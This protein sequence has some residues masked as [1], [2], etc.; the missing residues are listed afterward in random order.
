MRLALLLLLVAAASPAAAAPEPRLADYVIGRFAL[1]ANDLPQ[2]ST[3]FGQALAGDPQ[4]AMLR[5]RAFEMALLAG[6]ERAAERLAVPLAR[7][8]PGNAQVALLQ[9]ARAMK[10]R[11]WDGADA[12]AGRLTGALATNTAPI[13]RA[14]ALQGGG[15]TEAALAL[16]KPQLTSEAVG[17]L[18]AEH[19]ARILHAAGRHAEA[20]EAITALPGARATD[21]VLVAA[22][23]LARAG[24]PADAEA[25][26]AGRPFD[27]ALD[28][29]R[30]RLAAN[31]PILPPASPREGAAALMSRVALELAG[32]GAGP[33]ALPYARLA[34]IAAPERA[35]SA[36]ILADL[37]GRAG[38]G[39]AALAALDPVAADPIWAGPVRATRASLLDDADREPDAR[40]LLERAAAQPNASVA[41]WVRLGDHHRSRERQADAARAYERAIAIAGTT[42]GP[43][44]WTLHFLRGGALEQAGDWPG[45]ETELRRALVLAPD[46]AIV[47]NY[48]GYSLLDRGLALPEAERLIRRAAELEPDNAAITDSLG[49]LY[50][51]TGRFPQAVAALERAVAGAPGDPTMNEHLGDAYWQVGRRIEARHRWRAALDGEPDAAQLARVRAKLDYGPGRAT[52]AAAPA[53]R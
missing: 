5:R 2:A 9:Y 12:A 34:V 1:E 16:L 37:L 19:R 17:N 52:L 49:W 22:D 41:D 51:R 21:L 25:L 30:A 8:E 11:D 18:R 28:A 4:S 29:A 36:L 24:R 53:A 13:L 43:R 3:R 6:D 48:L 26:F 47:L 39:R 42:A 31:E 32:G 33:A 45:A 27:G 40:A 50:Y 15:E 10:R 7:D 14:W 38:Q 44:A 46:E 20:A 23:A 35:V